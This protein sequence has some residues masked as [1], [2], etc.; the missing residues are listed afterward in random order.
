MRPGDCSGAPGQVPSKRARAGGP[1]PHRPGGGEDAGA[2]GALGWER[3]QVAPGGRGL[4]GR[5]RA[6]GRS[7]PTAAGAVEF[8]FNPARCRRAPGVAS[9]LGSLLQGWVSLLP[10]VTRPF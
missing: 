8:G 2:G 1:F 3:E 10:L 5:G 9:G 4:R 6:R 7:Q